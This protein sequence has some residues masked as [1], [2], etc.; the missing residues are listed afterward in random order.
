MS[1]AER[2]DL[3]GGAMGV[4]ND[5]ERPTSPITGT[6]YS[7]SGKPANASKPRP[8]PK[9]SETGANN[10]PPSKG[11]SRQT[12]TD[13]PSTSSVC[14]RPISSI[15]HRNVDLTMIQAQ[16]ASLSELTALIPTIKEMKEAYDH[17]N[18]SS[19]SQEEEEIEGEEEDI[20]EGE[21][22]GPLAREHT[23]GLQTDSMMNNTPVAYL[24]SAAGESKVDG[25]LVDKELASLTST[26]LCSGLPEDKKMKL[27]DKYAPP[28]NCPRLAVI[29]CNEEIY[30]KV[31]KLSRNNDY[32]CQEIQKVLLSGLSA[33]TYSFDKLNSLTKNSTQIDSETVASVTET[34]A[35]ALALISHASHMLDAQRRKMFKPELKLEYAA[36]CN[37]DYPI[38]SSLFGSELPTKVKE[39]AETVKLTKQVNKEKRSQSTFFSNKRGKKRRFPF[40]EHRFPPRGRGR[41][42]PAPPMDPWYHYQGE[43]GQ[44]KNPS[45]NKGPRKDK[46][47]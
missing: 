16:L 43:W 34:S 13:K 45:Q 39:V 30:K 1:E 47:H 35:D 18:A 28:A 24:K 15:E 31:P 19:Q 22:T 14:S 2:E 26:I 5:N 17:F 44:K 6:C 9:S 8:R 42:G 32:D 21:V 20:E 27:K 29:P 38:E 12:K 4:A 40:L 46:R 11:K 25:P 41:G 3:S 10:K 7:G 23:A 33:L 37:D 36:L